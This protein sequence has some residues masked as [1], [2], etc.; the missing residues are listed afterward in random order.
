MCAL[1]VVR[2]RQG[3]DFSLKWKVTLAS[4]LVEYRLLTPP[5]PPLVTFL[6]ARGTIVI[7]C[8]DDLHS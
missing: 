2:V 5:P 7:I 4:T 6:E 1:N 8:L 3:K